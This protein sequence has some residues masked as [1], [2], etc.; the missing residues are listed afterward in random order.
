MS[1]WLLS[2][3]L[4]A[5]WLAEMITGHTHGLMIHLLLLAALLNIAVAA[6]PVRFRGKRLR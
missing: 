5:L 3:G 1:S 6:A 2:A 4:L